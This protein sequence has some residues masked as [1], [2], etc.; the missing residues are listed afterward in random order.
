[1]VFLKSILTQESHHTYVTKNQVGQVV[2]CYNTHMK[3]NTQ[4]I[5]SALKEILPIFRVKGIDELALFGSY[6]TG[7]DGAYSDIDIA[8]KK[9]PD[10]LSRF[11]PY[12]YFATLNELRDQLQTRFG[13]PVDIFDLDSQS[14]LKS[15]I[16]S[17]MIYA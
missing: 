1:M 14:P 12:A 5:L 6:A 15:R 13:R 11:S 17:E 16:E 2:L 8:I 9:S 7:G 4:A 3:T 10:F